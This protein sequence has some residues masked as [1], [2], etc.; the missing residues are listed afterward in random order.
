MREN[1]N[2]TPYLMSFISELSRRRAAYSDPDQA[3]MQENSLEKLSSGI[4]TEGERFIFELLQNAV[5]A[6]NAIDCLNVSICIQDGYLVFMHNGDSFTNEDIEGLCF[7]GRKGEKVRNTKKIGY[8]GIGF[9][10]VFGISS[11]VYVHTGN[12]CF[13]FDK[14]YWRSHWAEHWDSSFGPKPDDL[15]EYTMPWQV[16]PIESEVPIS[17]D[18]I[19]AN[20]ATYIAIDPEDEQRLAESVKLLMQSCRFLIFLKDE[21][22]KMSFA[23]HGAIQ[24]FIEKCSLNGEVILYLNGI[25]DSRWIVYRNPEVPLNLTEEQ[26]RVIAK[27]KNT[28]EKLKNATSFDLS[29]AIAIEDGKLKKADNAVLYTYLPTSYSFGEGF[30][31]LVN[32]NFITDEGRQHLDVDAEW[33]KVLISK[34]PEEYLK[35]VSSFST[36]QSNYYEVLPK[37]SYGSTNELLKMYEEAMKDAISKIAFLPSI[38]ANV[39]LR[40]KDAIIDR[41]GISDIIT[42]D[43]LVSHINSNTDD[44][45]YATNGFI[46]NEGVKILSK[47]GVFV[48]GSKELSI[49]LEDT[50]VFSS[51]SIEENWQIISYLFRLFSTCSSKSDQED[52]VDKLRTTSFI[53]ADDDS[54]MAPSSLYFPS[55][56]Y[57]KNSLACNERMLNGELYN[58]ISEHQQ[59]LKWLEHLGVQELSDISFIRNTICRGYFITKDNAIEVG[60]FLFEKRDILFKEISD[61]YLSELKF[62]TKKGTLKFASELYFSHEYEPQLDIENVCDV[63]A[64]ISDEYIGNSNMLEWKM[65]FSRLGVNDEVKIKQLKFTTWSKVA[66]LLDAQIQ[67]AKKTLKNWSP[68]RERY[69]YVSSIDGIFL[70]YVPL[71]SVQDTPYILS[72]YLWTSILKRP[73]VLIEKNDYIKGDTGNNNKAYGY[74]ADSEYLGTNFLKWVIKNHQTFPASTNEMLLSKDLY[75]NSEPNKRIA[76]R[77]LPIIDVD[78]VIDDS[79][80]DILNL[81]RELGLTEY[82]EILTKISLDTQNIEQNKDCIKEIFKLIIDRG[83]IHSCQEEIIKWAETNKI[84]SRDNKFV[85]PKKLSYITIDGFSSAGRIYIGDLP[86]RSNDDYLKFFE[87]LGV[88]VIT[89]RNITPVFSAARRNDELRKKIQEKLSVFA[90]LKA[91][92]KP[93]QEEY[94]KCLRDIGMLINQTTFYQCDNISLSYGD[95]SD[96]IEKK[97]FT[98]GGSFYYVGDLRPANIIPLLTP[99][100]KYLGL[101]NLEQELSIIFFET[102]EGIRIYLEDKEYNINYIKDTIAKAIFDIHRPVSYDQSDNERNVINGARGEIF[103]YEYFKSLGYEPQCPQ[104]ST[105]NDYDRV[106]AVKGKDYYYKTSYQ[107]HDMVIEN[108]GVNIYIE[109]KSS[110]YRKNLTE[111]MPISYRE[112]SMIDKCNGDSMQAILV[113]VYE[114]ETDTPDIYFFN[115]TTKLKLYNK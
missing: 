58:L 51:L 93:T 28:P 64:F 5:D 55:K 33:N 16:I 66:N 46:A 67:F 76:S 7:V 42:R 30:P 3:T 27:H 100:C 115:G 112:I 95:E 94:D 109:V 91:G 71:L 39:L 31:F 72:K 62:I 103:V 105:S 80:L 20:V 104:I 85:C 12:Q 32:A 26:K 86:V 49:L 108:N 97:T 59:I 36:N 44:L 56:Y 53:L 81:K 9:K 110:R 15:S 25:E 52:L 92:E 54:V 63:D 2:N 87:L 40:V 14:D 69:F 65:F 48:F 1:L 73:L 43:K 19:N 113:R 57:E 75:I 4:Y 29:F 101:K 114:V 99:L 78:C 79:W 24:C 45:T 34:I 89:E 21:N 22:I 90:L 13:R 96:C 77:F 41:V 88:R 70:Q 18:E 23:Y 98:S 61:Y 17:L 35:W 83:Y 47:Y 84:L 37:K 10:S 68:L 107:N 6:H 11:K 106:I 111:N 82:L 50:S 8:K 102:I 74:L 38:S 60:K